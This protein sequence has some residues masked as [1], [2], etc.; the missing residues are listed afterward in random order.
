MEHILPQNE[1]LPEEW[2]EALGAGWKNVQETWL[3]T[4]GKPDPHGL[5]RRIQRPAPSRRNE[6]WRAGSGKARCG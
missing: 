3:H 2:Q 5:Q 6:I 1:N 4:L